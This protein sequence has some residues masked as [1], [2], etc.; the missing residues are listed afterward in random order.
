LNYSYTPTTTHIIAKSRS[1]ARIPRYLALGALL[2]CGKNH[3]AEKRMLIAPRQL[4][5][6]VA[7]GESL[8]LPW[9]ADMPGAP[10]EQTKI[11]DSC[12]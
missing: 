6:P 8:L 11:R 2:H 4:S 5:G 12:R 1:W 9:R 3:T 7:L 10:S